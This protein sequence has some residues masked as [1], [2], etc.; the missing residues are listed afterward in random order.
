M[1]IRDRAFARRLTAEGVH[2]SDLLDSARRALACRA[3]ADGA[4]PF[5]VI[6][7]R[8][9]F[10]EASAFNRAFRRWTG[11]APGDWQA[12]AMQGSGDAA[13]CAND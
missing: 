2:Y 1:C 13:P 6:A 4:Q 8:L 7:R 3:V 10:S 11:C 5:V 12:R 9:G